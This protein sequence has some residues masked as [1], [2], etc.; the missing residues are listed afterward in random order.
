LGNRLRQRAEIDGLR[1][2]AVI[3]VILFHAGFEVFAGGYVGID[4]FLVISGYL[5]TTIIIADLKDGRFSLANFY[6]RRARRILPA[7][8]FVMLIS[9][10]FAWL[11]LMPRDIEAF[12]KSL[13]A[14]STFT[15][16]F[17][18]WSE[19]GYFDTAAELKPLLH[20]WSLAVEEQF[21]ILFPL[22][23]M[24][25]W[26]FGTRFLLVFFALF[27]AVSLAAAHLGAYSLPAG[28][29][30]LLPTRGWELLI[31]VFA[32]FYLAGRGG[33]GFS[34]RANQALSLAGAAL[35]LIAI[36][37]FDA[38]TPFPS[39][40][41]LVPTVG[42][43]LI[44]LAAREGTIVW[45]LLC[46]RMMVTIGLISYS[47]Y[48]WHFPLFVFAR[49]RS[50]VEPAPWL[51]AV[52]CVATFPLAYLSWRFVE[53][54]FRDRRRTSRRQII[55]FGVAAACGFI[56]L[57][58]FGAM[59]DGFPERGENLLL[60]AEVSAPLTFALKNAAGEI[61][62]DRKKDFC[63]FLKNGS[64]RWVHILGDS[65]AAS[66]APDLVAR[67]KPHTNVSS[68]TNSQCW[69]MLG[70][71]M[72]SR[73][74]VRDQDCT[75][76]IQR[77]RLDAIL[78][79]AHSIV[80]IAGRLPVYLTGHSFN[81]L[82][83]GREEDNYLQARS[84]DG[85]AVAEGVRDYIELLLSAGHKVLLVYPIPEVGFDVPRQIFR[86][87]MFGEWDKGKTVLTTRSDVYRQRTENAFAL[88]DG[89]RHPA[90]ERVFP[91][92]IFCDEAVVGK[93]VVNDA[94]TVFYHDDDHPA[95]A[96]AA[97]INARIVEKV[98]SMLAA[99]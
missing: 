26:R 88:L 15:S 68:L 38:K 1:A 50:L 5:I 93:C 13:F 73:A 3:P 12:G 36:F 76:D 94:R 20:T 97:L 4:I 64:D 25:F 96:G 9:L 37:A 27:G 71:D 30:Y 53:N 14:V 41:T 6:E 70:F 51:M 85:R 62:Y 87:T 78:A 91:H 28:A 72:V 42:T 34:P 16:N 19:A 80:V 98:E 17:L 56:A 74:G 40:Y 35:I 22:F 49:H 61:C 65:H 82:E 75:V 43:L 69:P 7:L 10:P 92:E 33:S 23:L 90:I 45:R 67:L 81:N 57:G 39:L 31:G 63:V 59:S 55:G 66:L 54:P 86:M 21:Y 89:I 24:L 95:P 11:Y 48:L 29:Y 2:V 99:D 84:R 52:L 58:L 46:N 77:R 8:F 47:A 18:F 32:A 60:T 44:I 83:G 79:T